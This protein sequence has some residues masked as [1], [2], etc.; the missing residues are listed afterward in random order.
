M[1]NVRFLDQVAVNAFASGNQT[2]TAGGATLP[3]YILPG[4]TFTISANTNAT[5]YNLTVLGTLIV[6]SGPLVELSD[7]TTVNAHGTLWVDNI[8]DDQGT[9]NNSGTIIVGG[10]QV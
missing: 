5:A 1:A 9:I 10:D 4:E 8:L 2:S 6:E 7:G 3:R